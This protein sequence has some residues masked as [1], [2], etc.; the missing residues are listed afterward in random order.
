M[1]ILYGVS[2][3]G[4]GHARRSLTIA[5]WLRKS[6]PGIEIDWVSSQPVISFLEQKGERILPVSYK[7]ESLSSVMEE[8]VSAGRLADMSRVARISS[9]IARQNYFMLKE[10]LGGYDLLIQDEF[11]ET[12]F[13]FMWD[14]KAKNLQDRIVVTDYFQFQSGGTFNPITS[15]TL[16]YANRML[17][18]AFEKSS[19]SIFADELDSIPPRRR[20]EASRMF[21]IV[22]PIVPSAPDERRDVLKEKIVA[23]LWGQQFGTRKL[24]VVAIGGTSIGKYLIDFLNTNSKEIT[25]K[26]DCLILILLGPRVE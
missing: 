19:L 1:R 11:S 26:L 16:W 14:K 21:E 18:K 12:M 4:L 24:I 3:V 25:E 22:G 10:Y 20:S 15:L 23:D 6:T 9:S 2:S 5:D 13:S 17:K 8:R 7:L